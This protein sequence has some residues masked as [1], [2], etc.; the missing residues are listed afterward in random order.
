MKAGAVPAFTVFC[1]FINTVITVL[2]P[3]APQ[4]L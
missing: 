3:E 2:T 4:Q 1:R